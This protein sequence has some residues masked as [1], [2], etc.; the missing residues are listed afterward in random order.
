MYNLQSCKVHVDNIKSFISPTSAHTNYFKTF[1]LLKTYKSTTIA[2]TC[3]GLHKPSSGRSLCFAKFTMLI[4]VTH[5]VTED[6]GAVAAYFV[7]SRGACVSCTLQNETLHSARY[8]CTMELNKICSHSTE[9]FNNL[10]CN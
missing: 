8:T 7:Q 2:P 1:K 6:F 5:A 3:F 10:M 4:S 9:I